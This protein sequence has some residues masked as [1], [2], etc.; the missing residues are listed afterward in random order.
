MFRRSS[1]ALVVAVACGGA[2][3]HESTTPGENNRELAADAAS[4]GHTQLAWAY[5]VLECQ[6]QA[7]TGCAALWQQ[8]GKLAPTQTDALNVLHA[9]CA[10][11][12]SACDQL[13]TW[14]TERR[15]PLAAA[16]YRKRAEAARHFATSTSRT[17]AATALATDL[18]AVMHVSGAPRTDTIDEMVGQEIRAPIA[19]TI[20][21]PRA[22]AWPMHAAELGNAADGCKTTA[23]RDRHDVPLSKCI[24]EVRPFNGDQIALVNRCGA[25][26]TVAYTG[27]RGDTSSSSAPTQLRLDRYEARSIG[28]SHSDVGTLAYA[29]CGDGCRVTGTLSGPW[30]AQDALYDC[31]KGAP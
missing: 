9:A 23:P 28:V 25:A 2:D 13:A 10:H 3:P 26:V 8:Y 11:D 15:H 31:A 30:T 4:T 1:L 27:A 12:P 6:S 21:K 22:K 5:T 24:G 20:S 19:R 16:A 17:T 18:A 7:A 14:H 29:V